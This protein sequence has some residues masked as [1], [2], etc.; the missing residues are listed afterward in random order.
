[1]PNGNTATCDMRDCTNIAELDCDGE[2]GWCLDCRDADAY[3]EARDLDAAESG[4]GL[5]KIYD[6][7]AESRS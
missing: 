6:W 7:L 1:M 5:E 3:A 2:P 4:A